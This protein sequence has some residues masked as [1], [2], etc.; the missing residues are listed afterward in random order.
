MADRE[1]LTLLRSIL[2]RLDRMMAGTGQVVETS[3]SL[4]TTAAAQSATLATITAQL[5]EQDERLALL[6][7]AVM[8][9]PLIREQLEQIEEDLTGI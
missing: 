2:G 1:V 9:L 5:V 7:E 8:E 3:T 6:E 4:S